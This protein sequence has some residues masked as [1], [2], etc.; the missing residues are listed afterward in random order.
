MYN[1]NSPFRV[2]GIVNNPPGAQGTLSNS[3]AYD[4]AIVAFNDVSTRNFTGA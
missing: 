3:Q 2:V 1:V 4:W